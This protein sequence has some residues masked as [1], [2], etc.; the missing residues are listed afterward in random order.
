MK[1]VRGT[2]A[3]FLERNDILELSPLFLA[4]HTAMGFGHLDEFAALYGLMW[5]TPR[6]MLAMKSRVMGI[7]GIESS[8]YFIYSVDKSY[9]TPCMF[10]KMS[11]CTVAIPFVH[12]SRQFLDNH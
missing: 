4:T 8:A 1:E 10:S 11:V 7:P 12:S 6:F 3:D 9:K 5:N 2:F